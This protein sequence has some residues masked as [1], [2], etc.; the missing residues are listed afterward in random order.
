MIVCLGW[1]FLIW[2]PGDLPVGDWRDEGPESRWNLS[3]SRRTT[4]SRSVG[5][6]RRRSRAQPL[7]A[8]D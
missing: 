1:G 8:H 6:R 3:G 2:T 4:A 7:A 5:P